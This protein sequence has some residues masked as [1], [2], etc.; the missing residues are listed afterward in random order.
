MEMF[1]CL[2]VIAQTDECS[3]VT[4]KNTRN[5]E[6]VHVKQCDKLMYLFSTLPTNTVRS[7]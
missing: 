5:V 3:G 1:N 6:E 7:S 4:A 2:K